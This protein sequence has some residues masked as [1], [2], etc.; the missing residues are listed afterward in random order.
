MERHIQATLP[1]PDLNKFSVPATGFFCHDFNFL[2][3]H[4]SFSETVS[5][6]A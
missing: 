5:T 1:V 2:G 3:N 6:I 4:T